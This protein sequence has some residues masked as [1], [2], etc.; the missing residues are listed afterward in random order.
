[1]SQL[2]RLKKSPDG[3]DNWAVDLAVKVKGDKERILVDLAKE[4]KYLS[5][6]P[7]LLS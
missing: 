2:K 7:V 3:T 6:R 1:M 4:T 5:A